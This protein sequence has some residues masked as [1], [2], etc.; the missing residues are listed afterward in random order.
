M[1][2]GK[3][4]VGGEEEETIGLEGPTPAPASAKGTF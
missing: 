4:L 3:G 1:E 2:G